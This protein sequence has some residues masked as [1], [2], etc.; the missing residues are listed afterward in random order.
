MSDFRVSLLVAGAVLFAMIPCL[1]EGAPEKL[2]VKVVSVEQTA[3]SALKKI[4]AEKGNV[5]LKGKTVPPELKAGIAARFYGEIGAY[6]RFFRVEKNPKN[7]A[8]LLVRIYYSDLHSKD[9]FK[10]NDFGQKIIERIYSL[11]LNLTVENSKNEVLLCRNLDFEYSLKKEKTTL[12][13]SDEVIFRKMMIS[14]LHRAARLMADNFTVRY[15]ITVTGP[16]G[17]KGFPVDEVKIFLDGDAVFNDSIT[18]CV[19]GRHEVKILA[20]AGYVSKKLSVDL[21][22][23]SQ[24]IIKLPVKKDN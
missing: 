10:T 5:P 8:A 19:K 3:I 11:S 7:H 4:S 14:C 15:K 1:C 21:E 17:R 24:T 20:P 16:H 2:S 18:Q 23:D 6:P 13:P 22:K 12:F 9:V